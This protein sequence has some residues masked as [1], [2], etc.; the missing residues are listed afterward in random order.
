MDIQEW[1]PCFAA[2]S[3]QFGFLLHSF[4]FS[5]PQASQGWRKNNRPITLPSS[6]KTQLALLQIAPR[7]NW[8]VEKWRSQRL[9]GNWKIALFALGCLWSEDISCT[10]EPCFP[11]GASLGNFFHWRP[12][13]T[14]EPS[15]IN[16]HGNTREKVKAVGNDA[17]RLCVPH[18]MQ[19]L[20]SLKTRA[21]KT[22][23][24]LL[25]GCK[26]PFPRACSPL[27]PQPLICTE[28]GEQEHGGSWKPPRIR[29]LLQPSPG[30]KV[31]ILPKSHV[32]LQQIGQFFALGFHLL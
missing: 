27:F 29:E 5:N 9:S 2:W 11:D 13:E 16:R 17:C 20:P 8:W 15:G 3:K 19:A 7:L 10:S 4:P 21:R 31:D 30:A 1:C 22:L 26:I 12:W 24:E 25:N 28:P 6:G 32:R 23:G 14:S 18:Q